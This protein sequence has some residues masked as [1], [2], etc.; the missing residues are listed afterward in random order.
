[1]VKRVSS[2]E[3][4]AR[5]DEIADAVRETGEPV[6][7][8]NDGEPTL[9]LVSVQEFDEMERLRRDRAAAE[10]TRRAREA[11]RDRRGPEPTEDEIVAALKR[12]RE[13]LYRERYGGT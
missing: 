5:F 11:A 1:M 8:E 7:V 3:I 6:I 13:E 4:R 9:A 10:F 12:T 2:N